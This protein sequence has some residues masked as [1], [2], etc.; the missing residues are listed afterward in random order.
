MSY[1]H[2]NSDLHLVTMVLSSLALSSRVLHARS[3]VVWSASLLPSNHTRPSRVG[4][5]R[6]VLSRSLCRVL[7]DSV[8]VIYRATSANFR[9]WILRTCRGLVIP[10]RAKGNS[11]QSAVRQV[12]PSLPWSG[13]QSRDHRGGSQCPRLGRRVEN[14]MPKAT[15]AVVCFRAKGPYRNNAHMVSDGKNKIRGRRHAIQSALS[16]LTTRYATPV[17]LH[18]RDLCSHT[19]R[20]RTVG[21][22]QG[23]NAH[24]WLE[25][26]AIECLMKTKAIVQVLAFDADTFPRPSFICRAAP[27]TLYSHLDRVVAFPADS[28]ST[29]SLRCILL[30]SCYPMSWRDEAAT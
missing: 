8:R 9:C 24:L 25:T 18:R 20:A 3:G 19:L 10:E 11:A 12:S 5:Q 13:S 7:V 6:M 23:G 16:V 28:R 14:A 22:I 15:T 1:R 2:L 21:G 4:T 17:T 26:V 29:P 27:T 30:E